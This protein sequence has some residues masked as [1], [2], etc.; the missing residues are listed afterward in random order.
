M[1]KI[2]FALLCLGLL[3]SQAWA[4]QPPSDAEYK[5]MLAEEPKFAEAEERLGKQWEQL[6][7]LVGADEKQHL[8]DNQQQW[9]A[10][11]RQAEVDY[12]METSPSALPLDPAQREKI[13]DTL[14]KS[15]AYAMVTNERAAKLQMLVEQYENSAPSVLSG[16]LAKVGPAYLFTPY[17][18]AVPFTLCDA[19]QFEQ[20]SPELQAYLQAQLS[21][22]EAKLVQV[23]GNFKLPG[24]YRLDADFS[25]SEQPE[26]MAWREQDGYLY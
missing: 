20:L 18:F 2:C 26:G 25:V 9:S 22:P 21:L 1:K 8:L 6:L 5:Q 24:I 4:T 14:P 13:G 10:Q 15:L 11:G 12:L 19:T 23:K 16:E 17:P 7:A 3:V